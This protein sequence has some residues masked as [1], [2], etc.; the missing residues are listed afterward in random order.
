MS[1]Q[2]TP[3][4][5]GTNNYYYNN[6]SYNGYLQLSHQTAANRFPMIFNTA[7]QLKNDAKRILSFGCSSGEECFSLAEVFPDAEIVGVDIDY[8][9]IQK[10]RNNNK[11]P[12]RIF[13]HT[14]IGATG[15]YDIITCLMVLFSLESPVPRDRWEFFL[16]K[17]DKHLNEGGVLVVYTSDYDFASLPDVFSKYEV[18]RSWKRTHPKNKKEYWCG[19]YRKKRADYGYL[20]TLET[21]VEEFCGDDDLVPD[22]HNQTYGF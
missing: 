17:V 21:E 9:S 12:E 20:P 16:N 1:D 3:A 19:Y 13:F 5:T 8:Y 6:P 4:T 7:K 2:T 14:D 15:Q 10:A 18:I 11:Q 22:D